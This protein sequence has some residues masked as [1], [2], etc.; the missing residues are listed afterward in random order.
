MFAVRGCGESVEIAACERPWYIFSAHAHA[1]VHVHAHAHV[2]C[3]CDMCMCMYVHAHVHAHVH[4]VHVHVSTCICYTR[5]RWLTYGIKSRAAH[6]YVPHA[7]GCS[8]V[9]VGEGRLSH[10]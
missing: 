1:H 5:S 7:M 8:W 6:A 9:A 10:I 2:T 4:V 3:T